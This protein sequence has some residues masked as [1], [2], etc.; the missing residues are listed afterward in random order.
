MNSFCSSKFIRS[1]VLC[2]FVCVDFVRPN[3]CLWLF[4]LNRNECYLECFYF[5]F[6]ILINRNWSLVNR[7]INFWLLFAMP[8]SQTSIVF[9]INNSASIFLCWL[10][11]M[12]NIDVICLFYFDWQAD[13]S[14][15]LICICNF[16]RAVRNRI[17]IRHS[18]GGGGDCIAHMLSIKCDYLKEN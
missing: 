15:F 12:C 17:I 1:V 11:F 2:V 13:E 10:V 16:F 4:L 7:H 8:H 3:Q 18:M 9:H 5:L 14:F 6:F